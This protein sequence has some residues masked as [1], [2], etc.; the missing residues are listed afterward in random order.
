MGVSVMS[1]VAMIIF[2]PLADKV[3]IDFILIGTGV[4]MALLAVLFAANKTLREAGKT[5]RAGI[6]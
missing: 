2:G 6:A 5:P 3:S 1:P 4:V